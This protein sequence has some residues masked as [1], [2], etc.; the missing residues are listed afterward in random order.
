MSGASAANK[1]ASGISMMVNEANIA[2]DMRIKLA[3]E[4]SNPMLIKQIVALNAMNVKKEKVYGVVDDDDPFKIMTK[5][6]LRGNYLYYFKG[7]SINT[8]KMVQREDV[9]FLHNM[10][11]KAQDPFVV[12]DP[13]I[14]RQL[15]QKIFDAYDQKDIKIKT[16]E[17]LQQSTMQAKLQQRKMAQEAAMKEKM[18]LPGGQGQPSQEEGILGGVR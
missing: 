10:F 2:F 1:T 16:K 14:L 3:Q 13:D 15:D 17:Q 7:N 8:N 12:E 5:E 4:W 11:T 9:V 18:G 6:K